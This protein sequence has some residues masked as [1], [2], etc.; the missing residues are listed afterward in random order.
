MSAP[1]ESEY[2]VLL[3]PRER[4]VWALMAQGLSD[5]DIAD[6]AEVSWETV[7]QHVR[8]VCETLQTTRRGAVALF[9]RLDYEERLRRQAERH[10]ADL[11]YAYDAI[12]AQARR[13]RR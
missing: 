13:G 9:L 10:T 3:T 6:A 2:G 11:Q 12:R 5:R 8:R 1:H 7:R 4:E